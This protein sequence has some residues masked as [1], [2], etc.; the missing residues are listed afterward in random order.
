MFSSCEKN[1]VFESQLNSSDSDQITV[2][3]KS[4]IAEGDYILYNR[5]SGKVADLNVSSGNVIQYTNYNNLNQQWRI[6]SVGGGYYRVSP[7]SNLD[8]AF[9]IEGQS[10]NNGASLKTWS[11][12]GGDNQQFQFNDLGNGYYSIINKGSGRAIEIYQASTENLGNVVQWDYWG[13]ENQQW[14]LESL[15]GGGNEN[16]QISWTLTTSNVPQDVK[17]R[18]TTAMDTAVARYNSWGNWSARTLTVEYNTGVA[19]ADGSSNGNIRFGA[20]TSYQNERTAMH[21]I[22]HTFG[23]GT[24]W[25][26]SSPL[27]E[28]YL[29]VGANAVSKIQQFDGSGATISTGGSHFWPYGLNYNDEWSIVN[30]NRHAQL[31]YAMCQD[32]IFPG[33]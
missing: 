5:L 7:L 22:A 1:S 31:V 15:S 23:V 28:N 26:W 13:G 27:I 20:N 30:A 16:G 19:T 2:G 21:E 12:W 18:I 11:Y 33:F 8:V 24:T 25:R 32:G 29:F 10:I 17:D 3:L 9:D 4:V 14:R 6:S